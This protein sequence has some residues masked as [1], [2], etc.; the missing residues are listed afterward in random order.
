MTTKFLALLQ[1]R[2]LLSR[3]GVR[4]VD[5]STCDRVSGR[6]VNRLEEY[7]EMVMHVS[8]LGS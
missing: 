3:L 1:N 8:G 6:E 2:S 4:C 5:V 7:E